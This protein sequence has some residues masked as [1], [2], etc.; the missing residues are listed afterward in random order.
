VIG[1]YNSSNTCNL[2][3]ICSESVATFHIADARSLVSQREV[4]V[5]ASARQGDV[6]RSNARGEIAASDWLPPGRP[7]QIGL[8]AGASTPNSI[9]GQVIRRLEQLA[10]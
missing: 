6:T 3:R 4:W 2:A 9:L 7:V 5:R 1:G 8:T 10:G